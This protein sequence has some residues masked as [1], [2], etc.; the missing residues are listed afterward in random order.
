MA[1]RK[2]CRGCGGKK[3]PGQRGL[4]CAACTSPEQQLERNRASARRSAAKKLALQKAV[5]EGLPLHER[6]KVLKKDIPEG[7]SWCNV[8]KQ[9]LPSSKFSRTSVRGGACRK[10]TSVKGH[11]RRVQTQY[12]LTPEQYQ[13]LLDSQGG[14]CAICRGGSTKRLAVDHDHKCCKSEFSCGKCV[15][16]L[17][18]MNCNGRLLSSVRDSVETLQRAIAY[19]QDPPAQEVLVSLP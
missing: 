4:Y 2:P 14:K 3:G 10:C 1:R 18:C 8:C 17:L 11:E 13:A 19:L 16:G 5:R 6:A 15:R 9:V 7:M 12:N